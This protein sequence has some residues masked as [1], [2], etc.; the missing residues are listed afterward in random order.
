[1]K[2]VN[3]CL[4]VPASQVAFA[5]QLPAAIAGPSGV[6]MWTTP[7]SPTGAEPATHYISAGLIDEQFAALMPLTQYPADAEPIHTPGRAAIAA[8]L[9]T[10]NGYVVTTEEV[11]ALFDVCDSSEQGPYEALARVGLMLVTEAVE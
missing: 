1:M 7:L 10:Q 3:R 11:Q 2:W 8:H 4:I 9:A 5:R 6:G